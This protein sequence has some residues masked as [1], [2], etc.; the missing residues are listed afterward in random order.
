[1]PTIAQ[2]L[3]SRPSRRGLAVIGFATLL[4]GCVAQGGYSELQPGGVFH[5]SH[6]RVLDEN[7]N[8]F[9]SQAP[10]GAVISLAESPWGSHVEI[11]ADAPYFAASGRECRRLHIVSVNTGARRA[12]ACEAADGWVAQRLIT[13]ALS[14]GSTR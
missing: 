1:M 3:L 12:V 6:G 2:S 10:A 8:G 14:V 4:G 7:L 13:D 11:T 5:G 9:L